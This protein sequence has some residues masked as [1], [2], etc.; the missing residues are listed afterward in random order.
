MQKLFC[1]EVYQV[2]TTFIVDL[3][4]NV[5]IVFENVFDF[6]EK[7]FQENKD[8]SAEDILFYSKVSNLH[9]EG[10]DLYI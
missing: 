6:E 3:Q 2:K 8:I 7:T 4:T 1:I 9:F 10:I 5:N